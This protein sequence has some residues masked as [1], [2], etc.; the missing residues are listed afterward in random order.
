MATDPYRYFR[1]EARELLD[2]LARGL[3]ALER[4]DSEAAAATVA[5][6]LRLA[7]TF[8]GAARVVRLPQ[9]AEGAHALEEL[10]S[11]LREPGHRPEPG[12]IEALLA[13][14]DALES[15]LAALAAPAATNPPAAQPGLPPEQPPAPRLEALRPPSVELDALLAGVDQ[16]HLQ[17]QP[18]Q[19]ALQLARAS[20]AALGVGEPEVQGLLL[21]LE[22]QLETGLTRLEHELQGL[23][24]QAEQ[25]RLLPA[26]ALFAPL[27][28]AARD[29]AREQGKALRFVARGGALRLE[30]E[31]LDGLRPALLQLVRNALAH[32]I[33]SPARRQAAGKPAEGELRLEVERCG[34]QV[35]FVCSDDGAGLDLPALRQAARAKGWPEAEGEEA[36]LLQ[37]LLQGGLSTAARVDG[38]AGR[39]V[40]LD[41]VRD[42]AARLGAR[43][44][45]SHEPGRGTR[46]ELLA[47]LRLAA[48][49][50]LL[51]EAGGRR[52]H[53]P[54][55]AVQWVLPAS[56][57][58]E[59][60]LSH[61]DQLLP[62]ADLTQALDPGAAPGHLGSVV[63]LAVGDRR[64]A[65]GVER[66]GGAACVLL[67]P[68]PVL[69]PDSPLVGGVTLDANQHPRLVLDPAALVAHAQACRGRPQRPP[70]AAPAPLVLVVD[71]SLTTRM[72]EQSILESAGYRVDLAVSAEQAL[73]AAQ[74]QRYDLFLVD[75]E[76]PGMDGFGFIE[77]TRADPQLRE[78]PAILLS[79]R[80]APE[81][82]RR[83][84][85]VGASAY[86]VKSE[87]AQQDFLRQVRALAGAPA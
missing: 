52:L 84:Q 12:R 71:D 76:M 26:E 19:Q 11:P 64:A 82:K 74:R 51:V 65:L 59:N 40:G 70:A 29:A 66:L 75:V 56:A 58:G 62:Y 18:L 30:A 45:L 67:R 4:E 61:E 16:S 57:L 20:R 7:H 63:L 22:R 42:T 44:S 36:A 13:E 87:F 24:E 28:R 43:L 48:L 32:G 15:G 79:S 81:D 10:L 34:R 85:A 9:L 83:G 33:E 2:Q 25:L 78:V 54:L 27:E 38:L 55:Q 6:L 72:L 53:L 35:R 39:G 23:R 17:L 5:L 8:K 69:H 1:I 14:L 80:D 31:L 68:A 60:G 3:L 50:T 47:P 21:R 46:V 86:I 37:R 49:D 73:A 41:L 77:R